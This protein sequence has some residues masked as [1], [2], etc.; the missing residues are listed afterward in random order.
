MPTDAT[1][2]AGQRKALTPTTLAWY[3]CQDAI[4]TAEKLRRCRPWG[5]SSV[6]KGGAPR[7][8][9]YLVWPDSGSPEAE[10]PERIVA[11]S[12]VG[13]LELARSNLGRLPQHVPI[14]DRNSEVGGGQHCE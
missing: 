5:L 8:G 4:E 6:L 12:S 11:R 1:E 7:S 2:A 10:K 9:G 13:P 3:K 14:G